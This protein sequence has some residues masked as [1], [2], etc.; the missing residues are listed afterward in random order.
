MADFLLWAALRSY[1]PRKI[2]ADP[3]ASRANLRFDTS[4]QE[5][6]GA[7]GGHEFHINKPVPAF[8]RLPSGVSPKRP[9]R[10]DV[11]TTELCAYFVWAEANIQRLAREG[12]PAHI[13]HMDQEIRQVAELL[14]GSRLS[15]DAVRQ[16]CSLGIRLAD[17]VPLYEPED[18]D[19]VQSAVDAKKMLGVVF[20]QRDVRWQRIASWWRD[21]RDQLDDDNPGLLGRE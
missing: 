6:D 13:V 14:K 12:S 1:G 5:V 3:W 9:P 16:L 21:V 15:L 4:F 7:F 17:T 10:E 19:Q 8:R 11:T 20:L 2:E 18:P